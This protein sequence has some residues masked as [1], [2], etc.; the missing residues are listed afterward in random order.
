MKTKR[1][2]LALLLLVLLPLASQSQ[3]TIHYP[4][5][6]K[7]IFNPI[8]SF[9]PCGDIRATGAQA[10]TS[11]LLHPDINY[12]Y[13]SI[14]P[15]FYD[16]EERPAMIYGVAFA[17]KTWF[18]KDSYLGQHWFEIIDSIFSGTVYLYTKSVRTDDNNSIAI[19][20]SATL[21]VFTNTSNT[22]IT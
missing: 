15:Y 4:D 16:N 22:S 8:T 6:N 10:E 17:M 9:Q 14:R 18:P 5:T 11:C 7:Y 19:V 13:L 20:D 2:I 1:T 3:D 12:S 21:N